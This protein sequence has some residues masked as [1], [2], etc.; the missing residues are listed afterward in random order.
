MGGCAS[1]RLTPGD[2]VLYLGLQ[3][4][5]QSCWLLRALQSR[6]RLLP[7]WRKPPPLLQK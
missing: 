4:H 2:A 1:T 6:A 7:S 3:H 5:G